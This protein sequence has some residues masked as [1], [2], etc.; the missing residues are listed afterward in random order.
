MAIFTL[1]G[2]KTLASLL[3]EVPV[4]LGV[5]SGDIAWDTVPAEPLATDTALVAPVGVTRLREIS[6]VAPDDAGDIIMADTSRFLRV[7]D[8]TRYLYLEFKLDLSDANGSTLRETGILVGVEI[9]PDVP[10]GQMYIPLADVAVTGTL[11]QVD[12]FNSI[13]R[14]GTLEQSFNFILTL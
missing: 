9:D 3:K 10:A 14:D 4:F 7:D 13:I 8:P 1:G 5:G 2:R 6:F 12:R 11:I